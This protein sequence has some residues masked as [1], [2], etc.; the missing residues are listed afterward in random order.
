MKALLLSGKKI[1]FTATMSNTHTNKADSEVII[2]DL[3]WTFLSFD[4][5]LSFYM[6]W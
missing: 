1:I 2:L 4:K 5:G 6:L 3:N